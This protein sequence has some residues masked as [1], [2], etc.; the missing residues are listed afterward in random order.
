MKPIIP[1][2]AAGIMAAACSGNTQKPAHPIDSMPAA[3]IGTRQTRPQAIIYRT[4][5]DYSHN[6]PVT[7]NATRTRITAYPDP[8]DL[9]R[10]AMLPLPLG[11]GFMLD[12]RGIGPN[13]AFTSYTYEEYAALPEAPKPDS[14]MARII[15]S[16]PFTE[17]Y[18]LPITA[19]EAQADTASCKRYIADGFK[20]C[21][22]LKPTAM[23]LK[24]KNAPK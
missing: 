2:L 1:I 8:A 6:V 3:A 7:L 10:Q 15:D 9:R 14:L 12:R 4:R 22:A 18:A 17:L 16:T 20:G 11:D 24:E 23:R 21:T 19:A 13:T 5:H